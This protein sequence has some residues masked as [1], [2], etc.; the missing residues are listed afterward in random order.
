MK[1]LLCKKIKKNICLCLILLIETMLIMSCKSKTDTNLDVSNSETMSDVTQN[2]NLKTAISAYDVDKEKKLS[3]EKADIKEEV[4]DIS[5]VETGYVYQEIKYA[6]LSIKDGVKNE[7]IENALNIINEEL[8]QEAENFKQEYKE[9]IRENKSLSAVMSD[10]FRYSYDSTDVYVT[11]IDDKY[12]SIRVFTYTDLMGA[13]PTYYISCWTFDVNTGKELPLKDMV[14]D[15]EELK[16]YLCEWCEKNKEEAGLFDE[17]KDTIDAYFDDS[18]EYKLE[19][20]IQDEKMYVIF[21]IYDI[22]PY[23]AGAI[24]I[25][26]PEGLRK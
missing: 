8:K 5:D 10:F 17:Y 22:A 21:Q 11:N 26:I 4:V 7:N 19:Y 15:K 20:Y 2:S 3:L 14:N 6:K 24:H 9:E 18:N 23:A 16:S 1:K 12:F 25:V 13:H